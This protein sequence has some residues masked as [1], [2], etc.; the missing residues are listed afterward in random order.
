M[1]QVQAQVQ[2]GEQLALVAY[3]EQFLLYL[4]GPSVNFGHRRWLEGEQEGYDA[5]A[6]LTAAPNRVLLVP[7]D[8][9]KECFGAYA[10]L[11]GEASDEKWFLV[12]APASESCAAKGDAGRAIYYPTQLCTTDE[13]VMSVARRTRGSISFHAVDF[14]LCS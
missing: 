12:R 9:L 7:Q 5:S 8:Q 10:R 1:E 14:S 3:K 11:A 4:A 6:W 13:P 2:P